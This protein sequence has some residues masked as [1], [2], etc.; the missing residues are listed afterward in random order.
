MTG[1]AQVL[2][3]LAL[4]AV[5]VLLWSQRPARAPLG[6]AGFAAVT[7]RGLVHV[8]VGPSTRTTVALAVG[9]GF[10]LAAPGAEW[11]VENLAW[12]AA[13][14]GLDAAKWAPASADVT[15]AGVAAFAV[16]DVAVIGLYRG[17]PPGKVPPRWAA[18]ALRHIVIGLALP[19]IWVAGLPIAIQTTKDAV[20]AVGQVPE[21]SA[22][23]APDLAGDTIAGYGPDRLANAA[24]IVQVGKEMGVPDRGQRIAL[25][26]AMQESS[27]RNLA[28]PNVAASMGIP[29]QGTGH[30][31]DSVGLFQQRPKYWGAP[32]EL[33]D[34]AVAARKF[35]D[36]LLAVDS[37][38]D[39]PVW[40]AAQ[41]V[42]RSAYPTAYADD[43]DAAAQVLG[44]VTATTCTEEKA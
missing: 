41:T 19:T 42:Q 3:A 23:A 21:P 4:V 12:L 32:A 44:A 40:Q 22:C 6:P 24:I 30:D 38:E 39:L 31:H 9:A 27:L 11:L 10:V 15:W 36:A 28:N 37:W 18:P 8:A 20:A 25:A 13:H 1:Y 35:Y 29:N 2:T 26:T 17:D 43:E 34:P 7:R 33:M 5:A 14:T 16:A